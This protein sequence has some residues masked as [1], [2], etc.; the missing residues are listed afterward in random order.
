MRDVGERFCS[1][2][3]ETFKP[4]F[5]ENDKLYGCWYWGTIN[6]SMKYTWG[7]PFNEAFRNPPKVS[8]WRQ[9]LKKTI[10]Y[11]YHTHEDPSVKPITARWW[12]KMQEKWELLVSPTYRDL[13][14]TEMW[15]C[16]ECVSKDEAKDI[17][18]P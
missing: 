7:M 12:L 14:Q 8:W 15:T 13:S 1:D 5:D 11:Y 9:L 16:H 6:P 18:L 17:S 10:P 3:G 4:T 2:C